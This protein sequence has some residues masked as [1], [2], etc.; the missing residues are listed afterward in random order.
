MFQSKDVAM[1]S[2]FEPIQTERLT[3]LLENSVYAAKTAYVHAYTLK[4]V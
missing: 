4:D 1:P 2:S 3:P